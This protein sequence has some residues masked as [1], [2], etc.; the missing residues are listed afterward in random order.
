MPLRVS[1]ICGLLAPITFTAGWLL[2]GLA[3]PSAYSAFDNDISDL[4]ALTAGSPWLYNQLGSNTTGILVLALAIGLWKTIGI[5]L[6]GRIGVIALG[7]VG[8]GQFL[9]GL[10]R[11]DCRE[12]DAGCDATTASWHANAHGIETGFTVLG[13]LV[14]VFAL[15]RAFKKIDPWKRLWLPT[16]LAGIALPVCLVG[17]VTYAGDGFGVRVGT[18]VWYLW[19]ALVSYR[20]LRIAD[21]TEV[22]AS[23][24]P[25]AT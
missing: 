8:V 13:T 24:A 3:Q 11:L 14:A 19:L 1:A 21:E 20:L 18:T 23:S 2:G 15:A 4:G 5:R 12:I 25:A 16:L 7:V 22:I 6:S 17:P 10:F 9:D